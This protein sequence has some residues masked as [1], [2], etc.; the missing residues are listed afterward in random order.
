MGGKK[1]RSRKDKKKM[2]AFFSG[3]DSKSLLMP[4]VLVFDFRLRTLLG[5]FL[6]CDFS[7]FSTILSV[8][9]VIILGAE[10]THT[11]SAEQ[12]AS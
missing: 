12:S 9:K 7:R 11:V 5:V 3:P 4:F 6:H 1:C 10:G 8:D 2:F